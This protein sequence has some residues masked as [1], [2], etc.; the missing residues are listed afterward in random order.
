MSWTCHVL[1]VTGATKAHNRV[2]SNFIGELRQRLDLDVWNVMAADMAVEIGNQVRFPDLVVEPLNAPGSPLV[3]EH[4]CLLV[5]ILSPSSVGRDMRIKASEYTSLP[6]LHTYIVAS[7][8]E[9]RL[10]VWQ[11][12][13]GLA[14]AFPAE[15]LEI[16]GRDQELTVTAFGFALPMAGLY[17]GVG[18]R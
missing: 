17:R 8:E 18:D 9:P 6:D 15:P 3:A 4:A 2:T 13:G 7:Q 11:R 16:T 10:W 12:Q 5:E 1:D 14:G